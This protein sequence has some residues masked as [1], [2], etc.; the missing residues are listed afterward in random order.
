MDTGVNFLKYSIIFQSIAIIVQGG[1]LYVSPSITYTPQPEEIMEQ[2]IEDQEKN[3]E[4]FVINKYPSLEQYYFY[5]QF[6]SRDYKL[7]EII[8]DSDKRI[9]YLR[10]QKVGK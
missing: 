9:C 7:L 10:L 2:F 1:V 4:I 6:L 5:M 3:I 8:E